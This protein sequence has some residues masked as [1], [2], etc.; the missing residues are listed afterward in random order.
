MG[1]RLGVHAVIFGMFFHA[2]PA[3]AGGPGAGCLPE[4]VW[5]SNTSLPSLATRTSSPASAMGGMNKQQLANRAAG[6]KS[7][8]AAAAKKLAMAALEAGDA[9]PSAGSA[10]KRTHSQVNNFVI[11]YDRVHLQ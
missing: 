2:W 4:L 7:A 8:A 11:D 1:I 5:V 10:A 6:R 3:G 9:A